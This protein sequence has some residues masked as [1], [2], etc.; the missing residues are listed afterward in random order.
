MFG[1]VLGILQE[2][3]ILSK[4]S[5]CIFVHIV[6]TIYTFYYKQKETRLDNEFSLITH[7]IEIEMVPQD[8]KYLCM[9]DPIE[10]QFTHLNI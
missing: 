6:Y 4:I 2:L 3:F 5:L 10:N 1:L 8:N 9:V 7:N